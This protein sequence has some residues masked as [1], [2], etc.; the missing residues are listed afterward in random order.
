MLLFKQAL[1]EPISKVPVDH[2]FPAKTALTNEHF[3]LR[4]T[5]EEGTQVSSIAL[6]ARRNN[7][8]L[9]HLIKTNVKLNRS[10]HF[11]GLCWASLQA[12]G[13]LFRLKV[14]FVLPY[15][16]VY[17]LQFK[18]LCSL[19]TCSA[20]DVCY[21]SSRRPHSVSSCA[22][23]HR[24]WCFMDIDHR[25]YAF[26]HSRDHRTRVKQASWLNS[27]VWT[28]AVWPKTMK[29]LAKIHVNKFL[30]RASFEHVNVVRAISNS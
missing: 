14:V 28:E 29:Q 22:L 2:I 19:P 10:L 24:L 12:K 13:F 27:F 5:C 7:A 26:C 3:P 9:T 25:G 30:P 18:F 11:L 16:A 20:L 17:F 21:P 8:E 15:L 23:K 1:H 6:W 4:S